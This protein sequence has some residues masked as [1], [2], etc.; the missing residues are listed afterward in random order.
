[1]GIVRVIAQ[2]HQM[3]RREII[4][5][6]LQLSFFSMAVRQYS[7]FGDWFGCLF[8]GLILLSLMI[9]KN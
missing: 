6:V 4:R 1:M 7:H 5:F 9:S 3:N 8:L 2:M